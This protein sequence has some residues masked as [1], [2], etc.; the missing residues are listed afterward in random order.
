[1][2]TVVAVDE[3]ADLTFT[4]DLTSSDISLELADVGVPGPP[5]SDAD[6]QAGALVAAL[7]SRTAAVVIVVD[8]TSDPRPDSP[9]VLWLGGE[10]EPANMG[11]RDLWGPDAA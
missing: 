1:M 5:G 6:T 7:A 2:S 10:T 9:F 4:I 11:A 3:V 8:P